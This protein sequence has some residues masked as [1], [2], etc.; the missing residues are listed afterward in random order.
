MIFSDH[1]S[2]IHVT[3]LSKSFG[4]PVN[5]MCDLSPDSLLFGLDDDWSQ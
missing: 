2:F 3:R 4:K 1:A 5:I